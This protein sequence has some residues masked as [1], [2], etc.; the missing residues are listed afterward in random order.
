ML[1]T[2]L[3]TLNK[4]IM[5]NTRKIETNCKLYPCTQLLNINIRNDKKK[6][7]NLNIYLKKFSLSRN[8]LLFKTKYKDK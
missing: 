3:R 6:A 5:V 2:M 8:L 1:L 4:A 7:N